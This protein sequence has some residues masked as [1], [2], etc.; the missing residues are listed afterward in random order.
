[1][2]TGTEAVEVTLLIPFDAGAWGVDGTQQGCFETDPT[3]VGDEAEAL[4]ISMTCHSS[5]LSG[6]LWGAGSAGHCSMVFFGNGF[7]C[8]HSSVVAAGRGTSA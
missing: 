8:I 2:R 1:M 5:W 3:S 7:P 6:F 4:S